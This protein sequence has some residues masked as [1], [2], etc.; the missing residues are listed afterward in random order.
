[1]AHLRSVPELRS[2]VGEEGV[3]GRAALPHTSPLSPLTFITHTHAHTSPLARCAVAEMFEEGVEG[4]LSRGGGEAAGRALLP[5]LFGAFAVSSGT[6]VDAATSSLVERLSAAEA[7]GSIGELDAVVL[8]LSRQ[9]PGD[10]G[11][12]APLLLN[13]LK[14]GPGSAL[15][16]GANEPHA[17]ISGACRGRPVP[18]RPPPDSLTTA[19]ATSWSAWR[20]RTTWCARA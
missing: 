5:K 16:L 9:F 6:A 2:V 18:Q 20:A 11:C 3:S 14:L 8:R 1:M 13:Y 15:F 4:A 17:Y 10:A 12:L 7:D 19:Q